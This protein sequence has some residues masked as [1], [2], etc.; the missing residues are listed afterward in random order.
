LSIRSGLCYQQIGDRTP[1]ISAAQPSPRAGAVRARWLLACAAP[2][3]AAHRGF[4]DGQLAEAPNLFWMCTGRWVPNPVQSSRHFRSNPT[5]DSSRF[6]SPV[7]AEPP[8]VVATVPR[9]SKVT[10]GMA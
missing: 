2:S 7:P 3:H 1:T 9:R 8:W 6:R 4:V 10:K 5:A